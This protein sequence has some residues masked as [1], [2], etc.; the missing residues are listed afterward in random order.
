V[1][2]TNFVNV[3]VFVAYLFHLMGLDVHAVKSFSGQNQEGEIQN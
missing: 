3:V 2:N 1:K